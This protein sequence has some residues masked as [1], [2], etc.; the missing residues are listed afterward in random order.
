MPTRAAV[1]GERD[2]AGHALAGFFRVRVSMYTVQS[3][4]GPLPLPS[5]ARPPAPTPRA[6]GGRPIHP[7]TR[8][9]YGG[10]VGA[11]TAVGVGADCT[12]H[13]MAWHGMAVGPPIG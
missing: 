11:R 3:R 8:Y 12:P 13:G 5:V 10:A 1:R 7:I 6:W 9:R 2:P 4:P